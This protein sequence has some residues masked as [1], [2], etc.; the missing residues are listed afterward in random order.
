MQHAPMNALLSFA[1]PR[2][3]VMW[4]MAMAVYA[5]C[6]FAVWSDAVRGGARVEMRRSVPFLLFWPGMDARRFLDPLEQ[7]GPPA[8]DA[9]V[10]A[11]V[12]VA[13]GAALL[14]G[15]A[16]CMGDGLA[17]GW[18]GMVGLIFLLHFG[19]FKALACFWRECGFRTEPLMRNPLA[20]RSVG[21][22]WGRRWNSAFRDLAF[23]LM[24]RPLSARFGV[25]AATILAFVIS[26]LIHELVITVPAGGGYGLPTAYFAAQGAG[27]LLEH[28][29]AGIRAG[30][31]EG[32]RGRLFAWLVVAAPA[33]ALFP[34][35]FVLRVVVSFM[36][37]I[38]AL[39]GGAL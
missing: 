12:N 38:G 29:K 19:L 32:W 27:M 22:F 16:G 25:R 36:R 15:I 8:L 3:A 21:D 6:K 18:I 28:S 2:W 14:W 30:L 26:G 5:V 35:Q 33:G 1:P 37:V 10:S 17:A 4:G 11:G 34:P 24:F 23:G 13:F 20:A 9:W 31:R 7:A 39:P